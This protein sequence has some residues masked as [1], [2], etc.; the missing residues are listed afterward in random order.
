MIKLQ[1][2]KYNLL[3]FKDLKK[4]IS[5][6]ITS[7]QTKLFERLLNKPFWIWDQQQHILEDIKTNGDW[8][9]NHI[10]GFPQKDGSLIS[11]YLA[12]YLIIIVFYFIIDFFVIVN[13]SLIYPL[14]E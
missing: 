10:I 4:R 9:F 11:F 5:I 7:Q 2:V 14:L 13:W 1:Y 12:L 8:C 3:T 6:E